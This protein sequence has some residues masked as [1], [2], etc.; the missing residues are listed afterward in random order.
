M[1]Q[2]ARPFFAH[3]A[4]RAVSGAFGL[5]LLGCAGWVWLRASTP[6]WGTLLG[7]ALLVL[8]AGNH[9][10]SAMAAREPWLSKIGPLP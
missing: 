10:W 6:G 5:V 4:Y 3:P 1:T 8:V 7:G 9:L 2:P